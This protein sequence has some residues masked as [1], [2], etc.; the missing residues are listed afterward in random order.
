MRAT[1]KIPGEENSIKVNQYN[2]LTVEQVDELI[3]ACE[4]QIYGILKVVRG[5]RADKRLS[6]GDRKSKL[7]PLEDQLYLKE[8]HMT[9]LLKV[10]D[11]KIPFHKKLPKESCFYSHYMQTQFSTRLLTA[12]SD[13]AKHETQMMKCIKE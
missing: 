5:L 7:K 12:G 9:M 8:S 10:R 11:D 13:L 2:A 4:T 1:F 3:E 6:K